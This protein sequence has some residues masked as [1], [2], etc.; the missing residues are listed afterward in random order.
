[1]MDKTDLSLVLS[2][3]G[4]MVALGLGQLVA[5]LLAGIAIGLLVRRQPRDGSPRDR[6]RDRARRSGDP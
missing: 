2:L 6:D 5:G 1:M 4:V 3:I